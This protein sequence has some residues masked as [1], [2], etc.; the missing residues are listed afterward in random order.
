MKTLRKFINEALFDLKDYRHIV[1]AHT[2]TPQNKK[3]LKKDHRR[4]N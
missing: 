1:K 2:V 3:E 4:Y